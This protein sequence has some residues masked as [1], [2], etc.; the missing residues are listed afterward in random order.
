MNPPVPSISVIIST[1]NR[2]RAVERAVRSVLGQTVSVTE[3]LVCD[4]GSD[5]DTRDVLE[6]MGEARIRWIPGPH[7]G[8]PAAPR[9]RGIGESRGEWLAFLDSDDEWRPDKLERQ[10]AAAAK[11]VCGAVATNA[12]R[13]LPDGAPG[14]LLLEWARDRIRFMDLVRDNVVVHSSLIVRREFAEAAGGF[15]DGL[16]LPEDYAFNLRIATRTDIA[17]LADGLVLYAD[18]PVASRRALFPAHRE[19]RRDVLADF[20][21]WAAEEERAGR[22][23]RRFRARARRAYAVNALRL[24]ARRLLGRGNG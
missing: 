18:E 9:N 6:R 16:R 24:I 21:A 20:L 14:G 5:D 8:R 13:R 23:P 12:E 1:W 22:L 15:P 3:V 19:M 2:S 11:T 10:L 17:Y 7:T 4:D